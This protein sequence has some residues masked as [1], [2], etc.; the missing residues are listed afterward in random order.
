MLS[1]ALAGGN[2]TLTKELRHH[3]ELSIHAFRC[4]YPQTDP[5]KGHNRT[6]E[7]GGLEFFLPIKWRNK[8]EVIPSY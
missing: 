5:E 3:K 2:E 7:F 6:S 8:K 1:Q 4:F